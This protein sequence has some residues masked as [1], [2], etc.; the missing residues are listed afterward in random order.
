[1]IDEWIPIVGIVAGTGMIVLIV[2]ISCISSAVSKRGANRKE[3]HEL[4]QD[5]SKIKEHI[6]EIREQLADIVIRLG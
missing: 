4:K 3:L 1:M 2:T 6:D 5:I